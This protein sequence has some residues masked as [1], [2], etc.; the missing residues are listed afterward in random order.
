MDTV[1]ALPAVTLQEVNENAALQVRVDRKYIVRPDTWSTVLA[2]LDPAP[3]VL[4]IDGLRCFR[5]SSTYYDTVG[6]D[7]YHDAA[8]SRPRRY[9]VRTRRYL[10]TGSQAVEVKMRSSSGATVKSRQWLDASEARGLLPAAALS[11]V[12]GFERIGH[13]AHQLT[14]VLTTT[15]ERVTFVTAHARVTVDRHVSAADARG[16]RMDYGDLLFVETKSAVGAG[17][18][19]RALW[20]NGIRP[21]RISKYCTSLAALR[22]DLPSNTWSRTIRRYLPKAAADSAAA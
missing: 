22:P 8:R 16:Q 20:A 11:F 19:D 6:L 13:R 3:S 21:T 7:S 10:D 17:A 15:Y 5:Y 2:A 12:G 9:K 18:V 1:R 14:E 4:D